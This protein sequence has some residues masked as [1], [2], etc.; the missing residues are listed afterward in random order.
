MV[1]NRKM[2][3]F[4]LRSLLL[5]SLALAAVCSVSCHH[6]KDEE[7]EYDYFSGSLSFSLPSYVLPG[8]EYDLT[9]SG[10]YR[11]DGGD[12][13]YYWTVSTASTTRDT[14]KYE[15]E[16]E[17]VTGTYHFTVPDS[18]FTLTVTCYAYANGYYSSSL[19]VETTVVDPTLG[20]TL[21]DTG[22]P[23]ESES[24]TDPRDGREYYYTTVGNLAWMRQNLA[25]GEGVPY[26]NSAAMRDIFGLYYNYDQAKEACPEGWRLPTGADWAD[27]AKA[28]GDGTATS[29]STYYGISGKLMVDAYFNGERLWEYWPEV[30][31]TNSTGFSALP[32]GYAM[33]TGSGGTFSGAAGYAAFW[34]SDE[35]ESDSDMAYYRYFYLK[36]PDVHRAAA[37]KK[38][39]AASVRCVRGL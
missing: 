12:F 20:R 36:L 3:K 30:K 7:V 6:D 10:V 25:Y 5:L 1:N 31:V 21:T 9:P 13:G 11:S 19:S 24:F 33:L 18:L 29:E 37:H 32:C 38:D 4:S 2:M 26:M 16:P 17:S 28:A 8:S 14:T 27:L 39:F 23:G 35:D 34:T 22:I 15:G